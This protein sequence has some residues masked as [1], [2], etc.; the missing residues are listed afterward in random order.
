M[1]PYLFAV[2]IDSV[3]DIVRQCGA[4]CE[5]RLSRVGILLYA[6][7]ILLIAPTVTGLQTMLNACEIELARLDMA[8]NPR[9]S[10]CVRIGSDWKTTPANISA[11]DG[12]NIAWQLATTLSLSWHSHCR[13]AGVG[14]FT[15]QC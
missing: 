6:D 7:D 10:V 14:L 5:M 4:G 9:K 1:S 8:I 2:Y 15:R 3:I 11:H 13:W 12:T